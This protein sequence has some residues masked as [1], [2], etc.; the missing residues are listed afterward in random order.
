MAL[1]LLDNLANAT[2]D[3]LVK[4]GTAPS[5][6]GVQPSHVSI[7]NASDAGL[8]AVAATW[9]AVSAGKS[10]G[11]TSSFSISAAGPVTYARLTGSATTFTR[12]EALTV[13]TAGSGADVIMT[14]LAASTTS[15]ITDCSVGVLGASGTLSAN[16]ALR[17]VMT[18]LMLGKTTSSTER[19]VVTTGTSAPNRAK[20]RLYSGSAPASAEAAA[21]GTLLWE[22]EVLDTNFNTV[23][24][25]ETGLTA[26][27]TTNASATG[28][29]GYA[30]LVRDNSTTVYTLQM[31]VATDAS[32]DV[33]VD[34]LSA[35]SGN[36]LSVTA[37][38]LALN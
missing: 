14:S 21:T 29:V 33:Q 25:G 38:V 26:S 4:N 31:A 15:T 13:G 19:L 20:L 24:T 30:R 23:A 7:Y 9:S 36:P 2:L 22:A 10:A 17:D 35:T 8:T 16:L 6:L 34:S 18:K 1:V 11:S 27:L 37:F 3:W 5:G 12:S 32:A 28:T